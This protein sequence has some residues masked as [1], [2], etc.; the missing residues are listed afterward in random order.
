M[1]YTKEFKRVLLNSI[2][3]DTFKIALYTSASN[4]NE[5]TTVYTPTNEVV[6]TGYVAGGVALSNATVDVDGTGY[7]I[8]FDT[9][10][11]TNC[12][13]VYRK[14]MIYDVSKGNTAVMIIDN[15]ADSGVVGSG[16]LA[17]DAIVKLP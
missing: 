7:A 1:G 11:F 2:K 8:N 15:G 17:V 10:T 13:I 5:N 14:A 3:T 16:Q 9:H 4:I 12:N 6:A